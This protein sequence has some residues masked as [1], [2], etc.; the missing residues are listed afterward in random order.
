MESILTSV[1]KSLGISEEYEHF[2]AD[3]IMHINTVF[4]IL[5]QLGVGPKEGFCIADKS[6]TWD[7]FTNGNL[8]INDVKS[9]MCMKLL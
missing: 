2:D 6:S 1:K 4:T 7:E 3:I 5:N 8:A 9:Y